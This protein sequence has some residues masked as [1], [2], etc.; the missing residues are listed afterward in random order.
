MSKPAATV[1]LRVVLMTA[2]MFSAVPARAAD[3]TYGRIDGD[4]AVAVGAGVTFGPR[5]PRAAGDLRFRYLQTAG[6][7]GSYED[8]PLVGSTSE[9]RRIVAFGVEL[10]PLFL[11]RW[12]KGMEFGAPRVDLALDSFGLELGAVFMQPEGGAFGARPGLQAG[13]GFD[14]PIFPRATGPM[15]SVHAGCRFSDHALSGQPL[16]GPSDRSI[17]FTVLASWQQIFG[18]NV[19]GL[20]DPR[21]R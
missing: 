19:V 3:T 11:A 4:M 8:G 21:P 6:I 2:I 18:T 1:C 15:L 12:L 5:A 16:A 7:F 14:V 9:P 13:I 20:R 10:R 17:Y